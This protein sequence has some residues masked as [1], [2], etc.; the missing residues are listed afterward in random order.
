MGN[1][2]LAY[3]FHH[4]PHFLPLKFSAPDVPSGEHCL[5]MAAVACTL[6]LPT[7]TFYYCFFNMGCKCLREKILTNS[8]SLGFAQHLN[9]QFAEMF[10]LKNKRS[11]GKAQGDDGALFVSV[12]CTML[13]PRFIAQ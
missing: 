13:T 11:G 5:K 10:N 7:E 6:S 9:L 1:R 3:C 4:Q 12:F 8:F 2:L